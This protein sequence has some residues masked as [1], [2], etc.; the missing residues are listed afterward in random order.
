MSSPP[1]TRDTVLLA[2]L[3]VL[4]RDG[5][6]AASTRAIAAEAGVNV[7]TLHYQVGSKDGLLAEVFK[8]M[9]APFAQT[10]RAAIPTGGGV[11]EAIDRGMRAVWRLALETPGLQLAQYELTTAALR[12]GQ[13]DRAQTQYSAYQR[14][15]VEVVEETLQKSGETIAVPAEDLAAFLVAGMDGLILAGLVQPQTNAALDLFITAAIGL[16]DPQPQRSRKSA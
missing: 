9:S 16:A 8:A 12:G 5:V 4:A 6:P 1:A 13:P 7:A 14:V 3:R 2:A 15:L 11:G 10:A